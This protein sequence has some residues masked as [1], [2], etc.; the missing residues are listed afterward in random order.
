MGFIN[1]LKLAMKYRKVKNIDLIN[2]GNI[3]KNQIKYWET[4][5]NLPK[6]DKINGISK[7][8][9]IP[10][11]LLLAENL[12]IEDIEAHDKKKKSK[13]ENNEIPKKGIK[14]PVYGKVA[15]G[16]PI[17]AITDIEEYEE[18][19]EELA[20]TG[21]FAAL[22]I[23]GNSMEPLLFENDTVIIK[24][25]D[26]AENNDIVIVMIN[27]EE[28]TCK[29]IQRTT[30]GIM[31]IPANPSYQPMFFTNQQIEELPIRIFGKVIELRR[32]F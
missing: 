12:T 32:P 5:H 4:H 7:Y 20:N 30:D 1:N 18:I 23:K 3:N 15:A 2:T 31:L 26:T 21:S 22:K 25:Q 19:T 29:R 6:V 17:E 9:D 13:I 28:A 8:L 27:G 24:I 11:E 16:V 10:V 14:I